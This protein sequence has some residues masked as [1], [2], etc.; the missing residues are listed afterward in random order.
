VGEG[1]RRLETTK[2]KCGIGFALCKKQ[3]IARLFIC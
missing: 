1:Q 3:A 2:K